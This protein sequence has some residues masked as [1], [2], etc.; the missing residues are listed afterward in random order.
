MV[1]ESENISPKVSYRE[2]GAY[3]M[4]VNMVLAAFDATAAEATPS[5]EEVWATTKRIASVVPGMEALGERQQ[6]E[7]VEQAV[8]QL[9]TQVN[10]S[11]EIGEA[12][13]LDHVPW[14]RDAW[15]DEN[16]H[17]D[18]WRTYKRL[19]Q[20]QARPQ[21]MLRTL[22][23]DVKKIL[24]LAGDPK[25]TGPFQ[26][27][28]L[29]MG[30]V[31]SGKTSNFIGLMNMAADAGYRLFIVIG[32][33]TEDLR[34]Q[35]QERVDDGFIG[36][37]SIETDTRN[38][39][40]DQLVGV[41]HLRERT[42]VMSLTT[43][44]T[45]FV[46]SS[47]RVFRLGDLETT[48]ERAPIVLVVKKNSKILAN[49]ADWLGR[50]TRDEVLSVPM[51]FIDDE[52]DYASVNTNKKEKEEATAVN[53]AI[54][55]ILERSQ[56]TSYVGFTAT[57]FANVLMN[58]EEEGGLF[59]KDFIYSLY[60]PTNYLGA[61]QYFGEERYK[62]A[63][64]DVHDGEGAFPFKHKSTHVVPELPE[65]L[66]R[67]IDTFLVACAITDLD[68]GVE[69]ARSMLVNVSRFKGVQGQV[70]RLVEE[71][72]EEIV[73]VL[74]NMDP[75]ATAGVNAPLP[76]IRLKD[77]WRRE[78]SEGGPS[79]E[80]VWSVL[81]NSLEVVETEL[82]N[83]DTSKERAQAAE[84]R[85]RSVSKRGRRYI[86]VGGT[87][88]SRGLTL[89]GLTVS[90]FYQRT[91]LSD[92]LLQMGRWFGYR[93]SY[94]ELV[95]IWLPLEVMEWF[96]FTAETLEEI[97][98]DVSIM[99][100]SEMTPS[101]FGLKIQKHPEALKVTAANK[102]RHADQALVDISF[103]RQSVETK[104]A[105]VDPDLTHKN[106][107]ALHELIDL[108]E[109]L[110][111]DPTTPTTE[112]S[113]KFEGHRAYKNVDPL[114]VR[115]F[116]ETFAAAP[117]DANFASNEREGSFVSNYVRELNVKT[118][119]LWDVVVVAGTGNKI[120][121]GGGEFT[122]EVTAN[123]RNRVSRVESSVPHIEFAN[124]RV[125]TGGNLFDVVGR[126]ENGQP[127]ALAALEQGKV[128]EKGEK[129]SGPS[130][131]AILH[132]IER[133]ILMIYP[134]ESLP[135][136]SDTRPEKITIG[137]D[138]GVLGLKFAFPA[139]RDGEGR[140]VERRA[141]TKYV[142]NQIW[143]KESGLAEDSVATVQMDD[144]E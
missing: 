108:C 123:R 31:Q 43:S 102:M 26:R 52:S 53:R 15:D 136:E 91:Q 61:Q 57:P 95:R 124:R 60:P 37:R 117:G 110:G 138:H 105:A 81:P 36:V 101:E 93:D 24:D 51:M 122:P 133:P 100:K 86:A 28:G 80:R 126:L 41:G 63:R 88:L 35:T 77:A 83:G 10:T 58:P 72:V 49:L 85:A 115:D 59:P 129:N 13:A 19:L 111:E 116:V 118:D 66:R 137:A 120:A 135:S 18:Y 22:E 76:Y 56:K 75:T 144:D 82:V 89:E 42:T 27:R 104:T 107:V 50:A 127:S 71:Y 94:R 119:T 1:D 112:V 38:K 84:I 142:V 55:R 17:W 143:M 9:L 64:N 8:A 5:E 34:S 21:K 109:A 23:E 12:V 2:N 11:Q 106:M 44:E 125:A 62:H 130:E 6:E 16:R 103:D 98:R 32:G 14:I 47:R 87:I 20:R 25:Q 67:A 99:R 114:A 4:L 48:T 96:L 139:I 7:L 140:V 30:D 70:Y 113:S 74:T 3:Q 134:I 79:W 90:Y 40:R 73:N 65:S 69:A 68:S 78:Y 54:T 132:V 33:H 97:R 141:G 131:S 29:V 121:L 39:A 45:D 92:T 128:P 46:E